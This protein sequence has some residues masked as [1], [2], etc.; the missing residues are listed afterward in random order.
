MVHNPYL[1]FLDEPTSGLDPLARYELWNYLDLINK[2]YG[3]SLVVISHYL[4]EIEYC[5]KA[6]IFLR[7]I[8]FYDFNSPQ[9]LKRLY[10]EKDWH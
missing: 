4:D 7:G 1:I 3:I 5:D 8:G 9:G 2:E 10:L 6:C